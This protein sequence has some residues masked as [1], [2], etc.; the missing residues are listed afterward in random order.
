MCLA[1][2]LDALWYAEWDRLAAEGANLPGIAG[3]PPAEPAVP[4]NTVPANT[5]PGTAVPGTAGVPPAFSVAPSGVEGG[6]ASAALM[7]WTREEA[8]G[9]GGT[10]AVPES[11]NEPAAVP[12]RP[13]RPGALRSGFRCEET[14]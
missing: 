1:C 8:E 9:A 2:E 6:A 10:P 11:V 7:A 3:V 12:A 13:A 4:A 5:F 14:E